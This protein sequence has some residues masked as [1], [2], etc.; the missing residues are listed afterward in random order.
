[1]RSLV[2][3]TSSNNASSIAIK[4]LKRHGIV[5]EKNCLVDVPTLVARYTDPRH[6]GGSTKSFNGFV[7]VS[8]DEASTITGIPVDEIRELAAR[9]YLFSHDGGSLVQ[10]HGE[11]PRGT[12][13]YHANPRWRSLGAKPIL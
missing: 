13:L 7:S 1:M 2:E 4:I 9:K 5:D 12:L 11:H 8:L 10:V 3:R 6:G